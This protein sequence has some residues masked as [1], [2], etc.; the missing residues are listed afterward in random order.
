ML[1]L[2]TNLLLLEL[3]DDNGW[4]DHFEVEFFEVTGQDQV[5]NQFRTMIQGTRVND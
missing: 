4:D 5:S 2:H 1:T 3:P